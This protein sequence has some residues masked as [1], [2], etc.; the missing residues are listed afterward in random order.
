MAYWFNTNTGQVEQDGSTES[1]DHL[2]G[3]YSSED[4]ARAALEKAKA[5][6]DRWDAEDKEWEDG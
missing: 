1:K 5:N 4:E 2:M 3:P 6:T